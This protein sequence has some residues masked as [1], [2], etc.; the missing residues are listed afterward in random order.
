[1]YDKL[2][3]IEKYVQQGAQLTRQ[4]LGFARGGK[5]EVKPTDLNI[6]IENSIQMFG[7]TKKDILIEQRLEKK[8]WGT[9]V[10]EGQI[11]QVLMNILMNAGQSMEEGGQIVIRTSVDGPGKIVAITITDAGPG[12]SE[13]NLDKIFDPFFTTKKEGRGTGLGL[14]VSYGIIQQ[15]GGDIEVESAPGKGTTFNIILP[16]SGKEVPARHRVQDIRVGQHQQWLVKCADEVL[17]AP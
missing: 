11:K 12:I 17:A 5:Y 9:V 8:L 10:D 4:L 13:K 2:R 6:L 3:N 7:R 15:H 1:M 14:S 16:I